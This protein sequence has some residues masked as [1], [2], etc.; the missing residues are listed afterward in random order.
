MKTMK[1]RESP[2]PVTAEDLLDPV[3]PYRDCELWDGAAV[4][5]EPSGGSSDIVNVRVST[6]IGAFV[7]ALG[8]G[9]VTGSEQGW[10]LARGPDRVLAADAA[11]VSYARLPEVP[12]HGFFPCAPDFVVETRS[13]DDSWT[14]LV[15]K[16]G[17]WMG[18]GTRVVW[19]I[20]PLRRTLVVLRPGADPIVLRPGAVADAE[21]VLPGF[22]VDVAALFDRLPYEADREDVSIS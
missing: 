20:D 17:V 2:R 11:F 8:L 21:P 13:P 22:R 6:K 16:A 19:A 15:A 14:A 9:W 1:V 10:L 5:R 18:H 12:A 4:V 3:K 7:E